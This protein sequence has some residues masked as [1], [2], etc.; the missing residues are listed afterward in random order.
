MEDDQQSPSQLSAEDNGASEDNK[1][2]LKAASIQSA[3]PSD[4]Q[5]NLE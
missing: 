2:P 5:S 3:T 1:T 4:G